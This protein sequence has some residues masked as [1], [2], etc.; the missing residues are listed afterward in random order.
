MAAEF[1][2]W[3][4]NQGDN[5]NDSL[6]NRIVF[7][8]YSPPPLPSIIVRGFT[9]I[10]T[11]AHVR[12]EAYPHFAFDPLAMLTIGHL[13]GALDM[14]SGINEPVQLHVWKPVKVFRI[15]TGKVAGGAL[16]KP[17]MMLYVT[18]SARLTLESGGGGNALL[19]T[20]TATGGAISF[21]LAVK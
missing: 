19:G 7:A 1:A 8:L 12:F 21:V 20:I 4:N 10:E 2:L 16:A 11:S 9:H 3:I 15:A 13:S 14:A 6:G 17:G 18:P 5:I